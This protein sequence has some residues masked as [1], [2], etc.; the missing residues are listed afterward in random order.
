MHPSKLIPAAPSAS[1]LGRACVLDI[2]KRGGYA[3][4][5]DFNEEAAEEVVK[6]LGEA[7]KFFQTDVTSTES[8]STAVAGALKWAKQTGKDI[9]G[10]LAAAGVSTPAKVRI[11]TSSDHE[12]L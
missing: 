6:E 11:E 4:V 1:G 2:C 3:A 10:V 7:V 8:I 12:V 9:G 5:L